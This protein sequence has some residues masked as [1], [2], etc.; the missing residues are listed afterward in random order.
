MR[1]PELIFLYRNYKG[2]VAV[3]KVIKLEPI[4][5]TATPDHP[6]PQPIMSAWC[7]DREARRSFAVMDILAFLRDGK[8]EPV[9]VGAQVDIWGR[10]ADGWGWLTETEF[11]G[12]QWKS[13]G[14]DGVP[15][16]FHLLE[17]PYWRHSV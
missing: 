5:I 8:V 10:G 7:L 3:R 16:T 6:V 12:E 9:P 17:P 14:Y 11:T 15:Y 13:E 2:V 1:K 4:V